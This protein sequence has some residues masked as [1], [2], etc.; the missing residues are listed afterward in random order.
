MIG[1]RIDNDIIPAKVIGMKTIWI[2]QGPC[3]YSIL[4]EKAETPDYIVDN[5]K[6]LYEVLK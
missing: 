4:E 1:D 5:L 6:S 3:R 2:R